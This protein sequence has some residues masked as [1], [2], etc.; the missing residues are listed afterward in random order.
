MS[1]SAGLQYSVQTHLRDYNNISP[2]TQFAGSAEEET[3]HQSGSQVDLSQ[4]RFSHFSMG[5]IVAW[6]RDD[7]A[8][9]YRHLQSFVS[10]PFA[11]GFTAASTT[12]VGSSLQ[13]RD[14][15]FV[16]PY[17]INTQ[18][19]LSEALPKNWRVNATF[20]INRGVHQLRNRNI[21][22]PY[23]AFLWTRY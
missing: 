8:I 10:D 2:T 3:H 1:Y 15:N 22:A 11:D 16:A 14:P 5:A 23:P 7:S 21:N 12:G 17:T 6:R 18:L 9:Q 13:M 19:Q 20:G 4:Y